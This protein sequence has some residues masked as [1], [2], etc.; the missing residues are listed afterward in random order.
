MTSCCFHET[1]LHF[2][3]SEFS[4]SIPCCSHR[5]PWLHN[6]RAR[7]VAVTK[8]K[9]KWWGCWL[10]QALVKALAN[11][12]LTTCSHWFLDNAVINQLYT[13]SWQSLSHRVTSLHNTGKFKMVERKCGQR[14]VSPTPSLLHL[15][16]RPIEAEIIFLSKVAFLTSPAFFVLALLVVEIHVVVVGILVFLIAILNVIPPARVLNW[17]WR[18]TPLSLDIFRVDGVVR[19][20]YELRWLKKGLLNW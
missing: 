20:C 3:P 12:F 16:L 4:H 5:P 6:L 17:I 13:V 11:D 15:P 19:H 7:K 2:N 14:P 10:P 8:M 9:Y 18:K 1:L